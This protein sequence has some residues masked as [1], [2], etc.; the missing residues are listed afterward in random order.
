MYV[1]VATVLFQFQNSLVRTI[2]LKAQ[3]LAV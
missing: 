3:K 2:I 1:A